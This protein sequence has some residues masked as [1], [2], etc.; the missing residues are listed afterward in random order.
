ADW[1]ALY[2]S[3][4]TEARVEFDERPCWK[5][6]ATPRAGGARTLYFDVATGLLAGR[7]AEDEALAIYRDYKAFDGLALP[8]YQRVFRP[9]GGIEELFRI[10]EV[11]FEPA[12]KETFAETE[13]IKELLTQRSKPQR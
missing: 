6:A 5:V 4:T 2:A 7:E 13:K 10:T 1:N 8:T 11:A 9:D 3:L 12:P